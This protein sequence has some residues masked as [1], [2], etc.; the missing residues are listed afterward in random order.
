MLLKD[1]EGLLFSQSFNFIG[2]YK[3]DNLETG[4]NYYFYQKDNLVV[5]LE[6]ALQFNLH[7]KVNGICFLGDLK[8]TDDLLNNWSNYCFGGFAPSHKNKVF[9][10]NVSLHPMR[11]LEVLAISVLFLLEQKPLPVEKLEYWNDDFNSF[12]PVE[13]IS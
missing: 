11:G 4:H 13:F 8:V 10:M 5:I 7:D 12:K 1:A 6:E 3:T 2:Q 9:N